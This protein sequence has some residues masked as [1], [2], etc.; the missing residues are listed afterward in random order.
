MLKSQGIRYAPHSLLR[1]ATW[2]D[3]YWDT[4]VSETAQLVVSMSNISFPVFLMLD[5]ALKERDLHFA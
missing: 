3:L 4:L 5:F 2:S 1:Q